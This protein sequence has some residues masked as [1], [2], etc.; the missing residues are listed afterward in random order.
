MGLDS[1]SWGMGEKTEGGKVTTMQGPRGQEFSS[2]VSPKRL[3]IVGT[4]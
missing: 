1:L 3:H 2:L 4:Q